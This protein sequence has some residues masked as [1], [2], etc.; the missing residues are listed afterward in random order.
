MTVTELSLGTTTTVR[1]ACPCDCPDTCALQT[2]VE[3]GRATA[4]RGDREHPFTRGALCVKMNNYEQT[5]YS[6]DRVLYPLRRT[7]PKGSG[8]FERISWDDALDEIAD[9]FRGIVATHGAEAIMPVSYLGTQGILNGL[10]VG[11]PFFNRLGATVSER[12]YC[13]SGSCTAYLMT[14]GHTPGVD[15]ESFVHSK[16]IVLWACNTLSTNSHH[17]PF[18]EQARKAG[19]KLVVIDPVKTRTARLADWHIPIRPGTD[20]ALALAL[21]NV[22]INENLV[23]RD[24]IDNY[25]VG[26]DELAERVA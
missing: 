17:W 15:P 1:G 11:D 5:V 26:Y 18:I 3:D 16:Y 23:D 10:N 13:D 24:Y 19:A 2:T 14:I 9:R 12:T 20:A 4:V 6:P 21:M 25:T 22:I 7:G 8:R